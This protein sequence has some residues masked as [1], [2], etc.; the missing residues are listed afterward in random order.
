MVGMS[1]LV[2]WLLCCLKACKHI[3]FDFSSGV[4]ALAGS[5]ADLDFQ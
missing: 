2:S 5:L 3:S 1:W 4:E